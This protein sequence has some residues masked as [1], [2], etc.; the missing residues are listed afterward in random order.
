M[1]QGTCSHK[2]HVGVAFGV[3]DLQELAGKLPANK[4]KGRPSA[5]AGALTKQAVLSPKKKREAVTA[6]E[7]KKAAYKEEKKA[8]RAADKKQKHP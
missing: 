7:Q 5:P 6:T 3:V 8:Q 1:T 2:L 4:P